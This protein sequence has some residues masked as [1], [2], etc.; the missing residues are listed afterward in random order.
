MK[1]LKHTQLPKGKSRTWCES[2]A[3]QKPQQWFSFF[4]SSISEIRFLLVV[5]PVDTG[6][7]GILNEQVKQKH[8]R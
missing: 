4:V 7:Q 5:S 1:Y 2:F 6:I 8:S 3:I